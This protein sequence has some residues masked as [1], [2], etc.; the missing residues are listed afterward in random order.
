LI[1]YRPFYELK[2][3]TLGTGNMRLPTVGRERGS[4]IDQGKA[5]AIIEYAYSVWFPWRDL[6]SR[7]KKGG[8]DRC[9]F[10]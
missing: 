9:W 10:L 1:I 3:S 7:N 8:G 5:Q 6:G 4:P 2:L